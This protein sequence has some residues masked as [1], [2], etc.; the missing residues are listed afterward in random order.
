MGRMP[1]PRALCTACALI[2]A[3]GAARADD[4]AAFEHLLGATDVNGAVG[5]FARNVRRWRDGAMIVRW[6]A[7]ALKEAENK[8]RRL[9]GYKAMSTL[10]AALEK[11]QPGLPVDT[12]KKAA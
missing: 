6:V 12:K 3:A 5:K 4:I 9:K 2:L 8:F 10:I 11:H 7:S 1:D